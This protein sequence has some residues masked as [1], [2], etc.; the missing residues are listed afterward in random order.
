MPVRPNGEQR[1]ANA[2]ASAARVGRF[3]S[4]EAEGS[5]ADR[6]R[7]VAGTA[8]PSA[9]RRPEIA[10]SGVHTRAGHE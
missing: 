3:A 4:G 2:I 9:R 7:G 5:R 8:G 6:N 1:L 10:M